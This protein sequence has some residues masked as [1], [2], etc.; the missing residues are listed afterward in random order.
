MQ[1]IHTIWLTGL[2]RSGKTTIAL[3]AIRSGYSIINLE[4]IIYCEADGSYTNYYTIDNKRFTSSNNLLKT[5]KLLSQAS[6]Y[7][8]HRSILLNLKHI[9]KF[10]RSGQITLSNNKILSVSERNKKGFFSALKMMSYT[11]D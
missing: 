9:K 7:R 11:L 5:Q 1:N 8:I 6:F 3:P 10:D 4:N 2:S